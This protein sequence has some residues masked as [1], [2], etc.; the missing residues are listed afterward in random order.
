VAVWQG[1]QDM[2]VPWSHGQWLAAHIPGARA[3]LL[4]GEGH[5]TL[6]R[7]F[8]AILADLLDLAGR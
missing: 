2:M 3:H 5:L 8:G 7:E 1:A 6:A 4:P